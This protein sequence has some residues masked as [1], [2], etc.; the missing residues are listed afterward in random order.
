MK[1][2]LLGLIGAGCAFLAIFFLGTPYLTYT[3]S[4]TTAKYEIGSFIGLI[5]TR[6]AYSGYYVNSTLSPQGLLLLLSLLGSFIALIIVIKGIVENKNV[7]DKTLIISTINAFT[8]YVF[9]KYLKMYLKPNGTTSTEYSLGWG[10]VI[11]LVLFLA[12]FV[13]SLVGY[14]INLVKSGSKGKKNFD[15][16]YKYKKLLDEGIITQEEFDVYKKEFLG[17]PNGTNQMS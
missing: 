4:G 13:L 7:M 11:V 12:F 2:N 10:I 14:I 17:E 8:I 15:E 9:F 16:I 1:K 5:T 6:D 3:R